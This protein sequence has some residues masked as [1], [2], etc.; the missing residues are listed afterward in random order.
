MLTQPRAREATSTDYKGITISIISVWKTQDMESVLSFGTSSLEL[1]SG[2]TQS[3]KSI[4]K[5]SEIQG[6]AGNKRATKTRLILIFD[7]EYYDSWNHLSYLHSYIYDYIFM[8][9]FMKKHY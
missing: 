4:R 9:I 5:S 2:A 7:L 8:I 3:Q 6:K 1:A